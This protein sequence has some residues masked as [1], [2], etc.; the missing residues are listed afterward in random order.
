MQPVGVSTIDQEPGGEVQEERL[1]CRR[2]PGRRWPCWWGGGRD[3]RGLSCTYNR[4]RTSGALRCRGTGE[5]G[6]W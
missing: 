1:L 6:Y 4:G 2:C 5:G 3:C